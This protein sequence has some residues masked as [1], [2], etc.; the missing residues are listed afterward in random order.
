MNVPNYGF[1][2][3]VEMNDIFK[4]KIADGDH[5]PLLNYESIH[6]A[7]K[8]AIPTPDHY[9]PLLYALGLQQGKEEIQFFNDALVAGSLTMTSVRIG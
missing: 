9:W 7:A 1:D 5:A 8:L 3:A 6:K 2:W 4:Q